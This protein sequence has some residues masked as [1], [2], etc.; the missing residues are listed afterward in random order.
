MISALAAQQQPA[1]HAS[2]QSHALHLRRYILKQAL[3][4][5]PHTAPVQHALHD[6]VLCS[7][8]CRSPT[9]FCVET[10]VKLGATVHASVKCALCYAVVSMC[11]NLRLTYLS[12]AIGLAPS[13]TRSLAVSRWPAAQAYMRQVFPLDVGLFNKLTS[14]SAASSVPVCLT[15][16]ANSFSTSLCPRADDM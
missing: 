14:T 4:G 16:S 3:K 5:T 9:M 12:T 10:R 15:H 11:L 1:W 8:P 6:A 13:D 7:H 2:L